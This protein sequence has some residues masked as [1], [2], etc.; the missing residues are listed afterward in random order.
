MLIDDSFIYELDSTGREKIARIIK[1][2]EVL[3]RLAEDE[4][5]YVRLEVASNPYTPPEALDRLSYDEDYGVRFNIAR[6]SNTSP[7]T[8]DRLAKD[9]ISFVKQSAISNP[10]Y[11]NPTNIQV[12]NEQMV[13]LKTLI[14]SASD[15]HLQEILQH[16]VK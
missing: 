13:A 4:E 6:H 1:D 5:I 7:E 9:K 10:N 14:E 16:I 3:N 12:T 15:P 8:L 11:K 2:P